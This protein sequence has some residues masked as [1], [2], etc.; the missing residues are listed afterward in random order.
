M[1]ISKDPDVR[2][3]EMI[4]TAMKVFAKKGYEAT[5]MKDIAKEMNVVSGLCYH[6]FPNKQ[7]LYETAIEE[8]AIECSQPF[9]EVFKDTSLNLSSC[10]S[11]LV[12][13]LITS[14]ESGAYRYSEFFDKKENNLFHRQME[15]A[16]FDKVLPSI[17]SYLEVLKGRK[18]ID[19]VDVEAAAKFAL[20]GAMPIV[21]DGSMELERRLELVKVLIEKV[22]K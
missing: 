22:F 5:T 11:H 15:L 18:E 13:L 7:K 17:I 9:I 21:N 6:Y 3:Q 12:Q 14:E 8:Y 1:R 19:V 4:D 2:R 16:M 10:V 20:N